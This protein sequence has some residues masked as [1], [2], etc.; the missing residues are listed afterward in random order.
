MEKELNEGVVLAIGPGWRNPAT[1]AV[2]PIADLEVGQEV[3][4]L[5]FAGSE[6]T[7]DGEKLLSLKNEEIHGSR[8]KK[9]DTNG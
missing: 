4:F 1:G 5:D 9:A 6:I 2:Q 3:L 7:I 8:P